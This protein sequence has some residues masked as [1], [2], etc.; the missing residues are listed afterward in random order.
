MTEEGTQIAATPLA[1]LGIPVRKTPKRVRFKN[2]PRL[3]Q[4]FTAEAERKALAWLALRLP[5]RV[6]SD[7]IAARLWGIRFDTPCR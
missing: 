3:Q 7:T 4:S 5:E 2:A 1:A 6:N